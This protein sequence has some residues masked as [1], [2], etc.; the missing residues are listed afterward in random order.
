MELLFSVKLPNTGV[1]NYY[2]RKDIDR[3]CVNCTCCPSAGTVGVSSISV[4]KKFRKSTHSDEIFN[5][6]KGAY[7]IIRNKTVRDNL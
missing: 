2:Y 3:F 7:E 6:K 5:I 1:I 4:L